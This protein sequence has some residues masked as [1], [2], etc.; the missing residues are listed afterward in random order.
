MALSCAIFGLGLGAT[1]VM[2]NTTMYDA[3]GTWNFAKVN[4]ILDFI[5]GVLVLVAG[6]VMSKF[7]CIKVMQK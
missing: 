2:G 1:M 7:T 5:S 3:L 4:V 6:S